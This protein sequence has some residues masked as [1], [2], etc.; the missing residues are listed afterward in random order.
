LEGRKT[1]DGIFHLFEAAVD[2]QIIDQPE[3]ID[4]IFHAARAAL[5]TIACL[6]KETRGESQSSLDR[7]DYWI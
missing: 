6:R 1:D 2:D 3:V 7:A 5:A 4:I